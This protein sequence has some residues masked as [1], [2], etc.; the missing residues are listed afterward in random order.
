MC[1]V[2]DLPLLKI[3]EIWPVSSVPVVRYFTLPMLVL[4]DGAG[5]VLV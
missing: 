4:A 5:Y 1:G 2:S 3:E